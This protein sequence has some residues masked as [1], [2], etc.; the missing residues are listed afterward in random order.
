MKT[1]I[2]ILGVVLATGCATNKCAITEPTD[3]V[4][5]VTLID[6]GNSTV[7]D[8]NNPGMFYQVYDTIKVEIRNTWTKKGGNKTLYKVLEVNSGS[9]MSN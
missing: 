3:E 8:V 9:A 7:E 5:V 1:L 2:L 6:D 4:R